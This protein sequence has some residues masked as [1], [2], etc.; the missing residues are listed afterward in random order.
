MPRHDVFLESVAEI[1]PASDLDLVP[2]SRALR[3]AG[4]LT[5]AA[6]LAVVAVLVLVPWQQSVRGQG[7]VV[8]YAPLDRQQEIKTPI[9]GRVMTWHVQ[10]GQHVEAG[11][12][13]ATIADNDPGFP[14]RLARARDAAKDRL[15]TARNSIKMLEQQISALEIA[16]TAAVSAARERVD[17]AR[18]RLAAA[19]LTRDA[20]AAAKQAA[21]LQLARTRALSGDGLASSRSL[22]LAQLA[23]QTA[24]ADVERARAA[25]AAARAEVES[26]R[27]EKTRIEASQN[28]DIERARA[29]LQSAHADVANADAALQEREVAVARQNTMQVVAPR[30]GAILR[31]IAKQGAEYVPAGAPIAI[32]VPETESRATEIWVDGRDAPLITPGRKVRVQFEGWPAVQF[33]GWPSVAVGTFGGEVAFVDAAADATGKFRVVVIPD[34]A[35]QPW[36]ASAQLRQGARAN[37]WVL[38]DR[39]R[40]GFE[41]WRQWN[42]FPPVTQNPDAAVK[43]SGGTW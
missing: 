14:E 7:R 15:E 8:A 4:K 16:R 32:L 9:A 38:L 21:D 35:D 12:L 26:L 1:V 31:Q 28:A 30:A 22:E 13:I 6:L 5:I 25:I 23:V 34:P 10:E 43:S 40:L 24:D 2:R 20:A 42:G 41:L 29:S 27:A 17:M 37:A 39:V 11:A 19:E 18:N 36:P 33:V 3:T